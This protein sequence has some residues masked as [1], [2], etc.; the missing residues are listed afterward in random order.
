LAIWRGDAAGSI[1][2]SG[3]ALTIYQALGER[4]PQPW[5]FVA[6]GI[7]KINLG[8]LERGHQY[9][10]QGLALARELGDTVN[11]ARILA[12]MSSA[13]IDPEDFD[14]RQALLDEALELV[15][16]TVYAGTIFLCLTNLV[17]LAFDRD[18][19]QQAASVLHESLA[20]STTHGWNWQL[21]RDLAHVARLALVTG[22]RVPATQLLAAQDV[23]RTRAGMPAARDERESYDQI[24]AALCAT[25]T[26]DSYAAAIA[27]GQALPL[28]E[29]I[30]LTKTV[31]A[32]ALSPA[33]Q[34]AA[35]SPA[36]PHG[37]TVRELQVLR[38]LSKGLSDREI[39]E[40]LF[41]SP[42]TVMRHVAGVLGKLGVNSRTAAATLAVREGIA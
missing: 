2:L 23:L 35:T 34:P 14:R 8:E 12:N 39:A 3:E 41:I 33:A 18:D 15:R 27:A 28:E 38:L 13:T 21:A 31:V 26:A 1:P 29:A 32:V 25:M 7:A 11:T 37:L 9:W 16:G 40:R 5:L 4:A 30:E 19:S 20:L 36:P 24:S 22:Q 17:E 42:H 10:Q 6:L